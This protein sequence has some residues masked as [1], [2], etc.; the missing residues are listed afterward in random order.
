MGFHGLSWV[1]MGC[2]GVSWGVMS[3][4][5]LLGAIPD[6]HHE[7]KAGVDVL[8]LLQLEHRV[9]MRANRPRDHAKHAF[10]DG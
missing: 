9:P 5:G 3:C 8:D 1:V 2:H 4:H 7:L 10:K 6:A